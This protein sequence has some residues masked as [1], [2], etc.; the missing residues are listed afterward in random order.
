MCLGRNSKKNHQDQ[1]EIQN[2]IAFPRAEVYY[3][4]RVLKAQYVSKAFG[5][6]VMNSFWITSWV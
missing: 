3:P 2:Y 6:T 5:T 1:K 4:Y